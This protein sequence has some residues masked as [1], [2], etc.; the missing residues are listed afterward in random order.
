VSLRG[1]VG[2]RFARA[3]LLLLAGGAVAACAALSLDAAPGDAYRSRFQGLPDRTWIGP[4][5]WAN[6][7]QDW[8]IARGRAECVE[9]GEAASLRTLHLLTHRVIVAPL[10]RAGEPRPVR[11]G[12][13][14]ATV[15]LGAVEPDLPRGAEAWA[16]FLFG[17]GGEGVDHRLTA[18]VHGVPA[19]DG[20]LLAVVDGL[21]RVALRDMSQSTGRDGLWSLQMNATDV[22]VPVLTGVQL[23][24]EGYGAGGPRPVDLELIAGRYDGRT[25]VT[26]KA[27]AALDGALLSTASV[28]D[29]EAM[30]LEGG[31]ALVSHRGPRGGNQGFW[32]EDFALAGDLV[33]AAPE[34]AFGPVLAVQYTLDETQPRGGALLSLT[35]QMPPLGL[36]DTRTATLEVQRGGSF[37]VVA[38]AQLYEDSETF[39]FRVPGFD[40][41]RNA[42]Y[43]VVYELVTEVN[44]TIRTEYEGL[45]RAAPDD[46]ELV[47]ADVGC[48]KHYTGGL[49]WNERGLWF[50]HT[51]IVDEVLAHDPDLVYFSGDQ[52]YEGDISA[53]V[54]QPHAKAMG[55][56]L[57]RWY[58]WCW[59]FRELCRDRPCITVADD[60]DVYHGN[61]WGNGGV[62]GPERVTGPDGKEETLTA[63]DRGG[64]T[65]SPR[66]VNA[67]HRTQ[68]SH[69]PPA[70]RPEPIGPGI[71]VYYTDVTFGGVSFAVLADRMF[72]SAP[73]VMLPEGR[74]RNGWFRNT[75]FDPREADVP[76]AELLG[77]HQLGFL[78]DWA[79]DWSG[80]VWAKVALSETPF[81]N[82]ATLPADGDEGDLST[83]PLFPPDVFVEGERM[84]ADC[85]SGGWPQSGRNAALRA[86]R[87]AGAVHLA[88]DQHLASSVRYGIEEF[89]DGG[90]CLTAPAVANTWP[91]R[92]FP[93]ASARVGRT[94]ESGGSVEART[95]GRFRDGFGNRMTVL[96]VAN[97][98][99]S[100]VEPARLHDY[101]PG[102]GVLRLSRSTR[103]GVLEAWPRF[104]DPS[105]SGARP[106]PGWP[107]SFAL[108]EG[109]GRRAVGYLPELSLGLEWVVQVERESS[110]GATAQRPAEVLYTRRVPG[111]TFEPPVFEV[112]ARYTVRVDPS[113]PRTGE[114]WA[115]EWRG[116]VAGAGR[117][118]AIEPG[119]GEV[120]GRE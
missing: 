55:D 41:R 87:R 93:P 59:S 91:R 5:F 97:P 62:R 117:L 57:T 73:A 20:G 92:W 28:G 44:R 95:T 32:F 103:Y 40:V 48:V 81:A 51:E 120:P 17:A 82:I 111:P 31:L 84:A 4:E 42:R 105:V 50:P 99:Q 9:G 24:G 30:A 64:Y 80:G 19:E 94:A 68:V 70:Y 15:R 52:L 49:R 56:Y 114:P 33:A 18:Q 60:H 119:A 112:G 110:A 65:M 100:G 77:A 13:F 36:R 85:D 98:R 37:E 109:D 83:T 16:G 101:A 86:F 69:L 53:P 23:A 113:G 89:D 108:D 26:L 1:A 71:S 102:Y 78:E 34:R 7:V 61:I 10:D 14:R 104:V 39:S 6:R 116:V 22:D 72:K 43:R 25:F 54:R 35:A 74:V 63:Q 2:A 106:Y 46:G 96:A 45:L 115:R 107:V 29:L 58:R 11:E 27:R 79:A 12:S 75:E 76:G 21:G 88:G 3:A 47:V 67:V 118:V 38:T 66:F 8:R 90:Y